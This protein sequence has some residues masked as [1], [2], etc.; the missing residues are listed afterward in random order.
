MEKAMIEVRV[1]IV[2]YP[3]PVL[4]TPRPLPPSLDGI[5]LGILDNQKP[6]ATALLET[7]VEGLGKLG[8][9]ARILRQKKSPPIPA[10]QPAIATLSGGAD[11]TIIGSA[12]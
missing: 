6:N 2:P 5:T 3:D 7:I 11:M 12:D 9:P 10:G 8:K 1:P 4:Q